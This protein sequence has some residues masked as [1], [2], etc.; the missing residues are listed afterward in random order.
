MSAIP[1]QIVCSNNTTLTLGN[2]DSVTGVFTPSRSAVMAAYNPTGT[3]TT[4]STDNAGNLLV[5]VAAG[6]SGGGGTV[7]VSGGTLTLSTGNTVAVSNAGT[8]PLSVGGTVALSSGGTVT[9]VTAALAAS[10]VSSV[11]GS[12]TT[13]SNSG[14]FVPAAGRT[15]NVAVWAT[16][17]I[18]PGSSLSGTVYLARSIDGGTTFLPLTAN[19]SQLESFTT[20][21][22]ETWSESQVGVPYELVCSSVTGTIN[23]RFSQ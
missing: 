3:L 15:F 1:V 10:G 5:N 20:V 14:T 23:Y 4:L 6:S 21:A 17:G 18:A 2:V 16:G 12:F 7:A 22:S 9:S 13:A 11:A 8:V 19:G